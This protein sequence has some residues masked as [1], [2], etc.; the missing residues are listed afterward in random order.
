MLRTELFPL[1]MNN[2]PKRGFLSALLEAV[3]NQ[4]RYGSSKTGQPPG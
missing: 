3:S 4:V 2:S 1:A